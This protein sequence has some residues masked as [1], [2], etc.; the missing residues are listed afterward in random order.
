MEVYRQG[1]RARAHGPARARSACPG[2]PSRPGPPDRDWG[3]PAYALPIPAGWPS[4]VYIAM[5][6]EI[7]AAGRAH[8]PDVTT[9]DGTEAKAL[10]VVRSPA[11]GEATSILFKLAWA[12]YHAYNGTG[13]REPLRGGGV[14]GRRRRARAS[15]SPR[16]GPAA[17]RAAS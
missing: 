2:T 9:P 3:W 10:F 14:D 6:V 4:G 12:T 17:G 11:P 1:A 8:A 13:L 7:D 16:G 15:R 5:L